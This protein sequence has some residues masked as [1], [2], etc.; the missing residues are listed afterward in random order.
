MK[1][2]CYLTTILHVGPEV[3]G[4][5]M[6]AWQCL[7]LNYCDKHSPVYYNQDTIAQVLLGI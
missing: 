4:V 1:F 2:Q 3:T 5:G 6:M 7:M